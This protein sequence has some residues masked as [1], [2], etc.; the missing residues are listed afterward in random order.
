MDDYT[1]QLFLNTF[2]MRLNSYRDYIVTRELQDLKV[3][4]VYNVVKATKGLNDVCL[5]MEPADCVQCEDNF[6]NG[7]DCCVYLSSSRAEINTVT[8]IPQICQLAGELKKRLLAELIVV[9]KGECESHTTW[10][11][12]VKD[13]SDCN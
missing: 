7:G 6:H 8:S 13:C 11:F 10:R 1:K 12:S 5:S 4:V 3:G 2:L 9:K